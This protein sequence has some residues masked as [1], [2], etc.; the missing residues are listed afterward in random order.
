VCI[1][2]DNLGKNDGAVVLRKKYFCNTLGVLLCK[3]S[4]EM[5]VTGAESGGGIHNT[6]TAWA[7]AVV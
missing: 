4:K 5:V 6:T 3:S 1:I 2:L 7:A